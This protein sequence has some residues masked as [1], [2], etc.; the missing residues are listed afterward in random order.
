[1]SN[2]FKT[3]T[4][5]ALLAIGVSFVLIIYAEASP[6]LDRNAFRLGSATRHGGSMEMQQG[7]MGQPS[8]MMG[9]CSSM[10]QSQ[11]QPPNSQFRK[12]QQQPSQNE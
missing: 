12:P 6:A 11:N 1:M 10:M 3:M 8:Q 2:P 7:M 4:V 9:G 5:G